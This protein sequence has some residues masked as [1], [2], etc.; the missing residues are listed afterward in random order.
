MHETLQPG[1][2]ENSNDHVT[3]ALKAA[4]KCTVKNKFQVALFLDNK[5]KVKPY[6]TIQ[7]R[8]KKAVESAITRLTWT[9]REH[10][11]RFGSIR[12]IVQV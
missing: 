2:M 7:K 9:Y 12:P 5:S 11:V 4:E 8:T 1:R 6:L 3:K 10:E